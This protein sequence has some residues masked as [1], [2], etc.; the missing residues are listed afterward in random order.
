[1]QYNAQAATRRSDVCLA[2]GQL[3]CD[4]VSADFQL[5]KTDTICNGLLRGKYKIPL[6]GTNVSQSDSRTTGDKTRCVGCGACLQRKRAHKGRP[7]DAV[8]QA[9]TQ[10]RQLKVAS[11]HAQ[12][13]VTVLQQ[14]GRAQRWIAKTCRNR[15]CRN[16]YSAFGRI[17]G[18]RKITREGGATKARNRTGARHRDRSLRTTA[19]RIRTADICQTTGQAASQPCRR[20]ISQRQCRFNAKRRWR[21]SDRP[22]AS[23][24][25]PLN[26]QRRT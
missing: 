18:N 11:S 3:P 5:L 10:C 12:I 21:N 1:M 20:T 8:N 4:I 9:G 26:I 14:D 24:T 6:Q 23:Q 7:C 22:I 17:I 2:K 13:K 19:K 16:S 15:R 25:H